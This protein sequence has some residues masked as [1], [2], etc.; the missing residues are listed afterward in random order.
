MKIFGFEIKKSPPAAPRRR[1][2]EAAKSSGLT[3]DWMTSGN[4]T[5]DETLRWQLP[6][7]RERARSLEQ[8]SD[9]MKNFLRKLRVNVVGPNGIRM[10]SK[11][12]FRNGSLDKSTNQTIEDAW[13][14]WCKKNNASITGQQSLRSILNTVITRVATDGDIL[15]HKIV[16]RSAG[17]RFNFSLK[18][19]ES[20]HLA[21]HLN[22]TLPNG[23]TI[24]LGVEKNADGRTVAYHLFTKHP[25]GNAYV[26]AEQG[27]RIMR[28][29]AEEIIMP[30][31]QERPTQSRG[32]PWAH[33]AVIRLRM[34]G[35]YEEAAVVNARIGASKMQS[36][37][38]GEGQEYGE[39]ELK[40]EYGN[41]VQEIEPGMREVLPHGTE[42]H[43]SNP[44]FPNNEHGAF[45][46]AMLRGISSGLGCS[47]NSLANDLEG[48]NF[49]SLRSG[50]LEERDGYMVIQQWLIEAVLDD[51]FESWLEVQTLTG[52]LGLANASALD[53]DRI[54][55]P[56][57]MPRRWP[58]VDPAK[59]VRAKLDELGGGLTSRTAICA[60]KGVDFEELLEQLAEEEKLAKQ[61][62]ITFAQ[63]DPAKQSDKVPSDEEDDAAMAA[64][65][66]KNGGNGNGKKTHN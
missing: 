12:R 21:E 34:L 41:I 25:G 27:R 1:N 63:I 22:T 4:L 10:Q 5:A 19:Y 42:I 37:I 3:S 14:C 65:Q 45:T 26:A 50:A 46:K 44:D 33:T 60:E 9:Y 35:A 36:I 30:F 31:D 29:P 16:G 38:M 49:S 15:I 51:V 54:C 53:M 47:Y 66:P 61:Y 24:S 64:Q 2:Y 17:N 58:W 40:D 28:I 8:N 62:G 59:D 55:K 20:D 6:K 23:N 7:I 39:G 48:V 57:W 32:I 52:N 18:L 11:A 43:D 13:Q 56:F